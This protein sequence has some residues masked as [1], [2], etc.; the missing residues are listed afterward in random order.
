MA[1]T[2]IITLDLNFQNSPNAIACYLIRHS[3][4]GVLVECGPGST[5]EELK[6]GLARNGLGVSDVTHVLLT[7][8]H[9]D[10]A[11]A[12]G[13][14][15]RQG[16]QIVVHPV[17]APHLISPERLL[18]SAARIYGDRMNEL[19]G[20]FQAVPASHVTVPQ[21]GREIA[22]GNLRF[23]PVDTP[24]HAEHHYAYLFEGTCFSGDVGG[25]RILP[26][27]YLRIPMPPPELNLQKWRRSLARL[28]SEAFDRIAPTHFGIHADCV[29]HLQAVERGLDEVERWLEHAMAGDPGIEELRAAFTDW[30]TAQAAEHGLPAEALR[31]L[32]FANPVGMSADGLFRYWNKVRLAR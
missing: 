21:D 5:R 23:V 15:A 1:K 29:W 20:E 28:R 26:N 24:G 4:G 32:E 19:W 31:A 8:V 25:V 7:H 3:T 27:R 14:M 6:A 10:H 13:W 30:M 11:G 9:L 17:G 18:A 2:D 16:A 12:A 22:I